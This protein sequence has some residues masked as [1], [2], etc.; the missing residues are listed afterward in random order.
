M[1][2]TLPVAEATAN[3]FSDVLAFPDLRIAADVEADHPQ[4]GVCGG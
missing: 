1:T 2:K 4:L 3:E